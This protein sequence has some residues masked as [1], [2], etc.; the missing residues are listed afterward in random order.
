M[1]GSPVTTDPHWQ[2]DLGSWSEDEETERLWR[3]MLELQRH[4]RCYNS[5]R[6]DA[7][8]DDENMSAIVPPRSCLDLLNDSIGALPE[9][10]Q[11]ELDNFLER[12]DGPARRKHRIWGI[13][14][15][16]SY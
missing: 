14:V 4:F 3:R 13:P 11:R 6:M 2:L 16:I 8:V 9:E 7:A 10:A 12:L 1:E 5:A 15:G